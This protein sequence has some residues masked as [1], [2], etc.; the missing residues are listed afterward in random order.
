MDIICE[1]II[2]EKKLPFV[3]LGFP[4]WTRRR[5]I[6]Y[7]L[8]EKWEHLF[9]RLYKVDRIDDTNVLR[10]SLTRY[11]GEDLYE[12][13]RLIARKGDVVAEIHLDSVRL[14]S[15]NMDV[16]ALGIKALR[17]VRRS[18]PGLAAYI[19]EN[20]KYEDINVFIGLTLINR[21]VKGLGFNVQDIKPSF[22]TRFVGK[23]QKAIMNNFHPA[24][25]GRENSRL[26]DQPKLIW[27]SRHV[28]LEKW[29]A[30]ETP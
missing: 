18:F 6:G 26:G 10:L 22:F 27:M 1:H 2:I 9:A 16:Q 3:P 4:Q 21:G 15:D 30:K 14:Q 8:F 17:K 7:V 11:K 5:R 23:I 20:P 28:L 19:L 25:K 29:L 12:N 24:G 13:D